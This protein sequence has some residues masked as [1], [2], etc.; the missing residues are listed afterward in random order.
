MSKALASSG[1]GW[2]GGERLP[3]PRAA[4]E[5]IAPYI[6]GYWIDLIQIIAEESANK[7]SANANRL[8]R[9]VP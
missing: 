3:N 6:G 5:R 1:P 9:G 7:P 8:E 4:Y 2:R